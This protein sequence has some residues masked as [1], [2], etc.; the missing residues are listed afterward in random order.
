M[1]WTGMGLAELGLAGLA[2]W[3][4]VERTGGSICWPMA[5]WDIFEIHINIFID[6][7]I[8]ILGRCVRILFKSFSFEQFLE[9][10]FRDTHRYMGVLIN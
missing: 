5:A 9:V 1:A 7:C 3:P 4:G 8:E 10:R 6:I 2:G